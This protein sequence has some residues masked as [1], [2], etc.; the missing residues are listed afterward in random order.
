MRGLT[1]R[2]PPPGKLWRVHRDPQALPRRSE[3]P[4]PNRY[5]DPRPKADDRFLVR[6]LSTTLRGCLLETLAWARPNREAL[7]RLERVVDR[8]AGPEKDESLADAVADFLKSRKAAACSLA[9]VEDL[10]DIHAPGTLAALDTD[11]NVEPLLA[12]TRARS[13]LGEAGSVNRPRLDQ[14]AV[15]LASDFGRQLTQHCS[16]AIWDVKPS[17]GGV[18]YR[19]RYDLNEW[20]WAVYD[21]TGVVF[22]DAI[23]LSPRVDHHYEAVHDVAELWSLPL[24]RWL[25]QV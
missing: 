16:L 5:D 23:P 2:R 20:C 1:P 10:V 14:A 9:E 3:Q 18:A 21:R 11:L 13:V 15:L 12:T 7:Q 8:D 24:N 6:Y 25:D 4:G 19:S 22:D 17:R